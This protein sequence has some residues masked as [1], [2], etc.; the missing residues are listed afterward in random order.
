MQAYFISLE[1]LWKGGE[2][3]VIISIPNKD[4]FVFVVVVNEK[5]Y[6][7][8]F[9][10]VSNTSCITNCLALLAKKEGDADV[11]MESIK[12][13]EENIVSDTAKGHLTEKQEKTRDRIIKRTGKVMSNGRGRGLKGI[14][15]KI[16]I[17]AVVLLICTLSLL[18]SATI[19]GNRRSLQ[20]SDVEKL[21][22]TAKTGGW[23]PSFAPTTNAATFIPTPTGLAN[24][25]FHF[26]ENSQLLPPFAQKDVETVRVSPPELML[27]PDISAFIRRRAA[28]YPMFVMI[29][30]NIVSKTSFKT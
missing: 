30:R 9:D 3:K 23:R 4:A 21:W 22:E 7:P 2:K 20:P 28:A 18:L 26:F 15:T 13:P 5:K 12:K 10:I 25:T 8:S 16:T 24:A 1:C 19:T 11:F 14:Y 29:E 17:V 6:K 27:V